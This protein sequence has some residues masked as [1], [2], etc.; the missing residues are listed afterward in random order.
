MMVSALL[1]ETRSSR[2]KSEP[3]LPCPTPCKSGVRFL[4]PVIHCPR[5]QPLTKEAQD[6]GISKPSVI[7]QARVTGNVLPGESGSCPEEA[8]LGPSST[9]WRH[10]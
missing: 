4:S 1:C 2:A 7:C 3:L 8:G 5:S 6:A 9:R 10:P